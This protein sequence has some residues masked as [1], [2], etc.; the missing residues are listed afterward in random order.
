MNSDRPASR[1]VREM[2]GKD[3]P[4]P[5]EAERAV[6]QEVLAAMRHIRHGSIELALQDGRVVQ[7]N[8]TEKRRL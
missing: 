6:L 8:T 5:T 1:W 4:P 2:L 3:A 7:L